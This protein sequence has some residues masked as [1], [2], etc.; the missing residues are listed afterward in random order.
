MT[1]NLEG[2]SMMANTEKI[3]QDS[4]NY[5]EYV[6]AVTIIGFEDGRELEIDDKLNM[7]NTSEVSVTVANGDYCSYSYIV[8]GNSLIFTV[9]IL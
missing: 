6:N 8:N 1:K 9:V 5:F 4:L 7:S 3:S 2:L